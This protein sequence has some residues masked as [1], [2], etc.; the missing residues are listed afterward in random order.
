MN[1]LSDCAPCLFIRIIVC[2]SVG[3]IPDALEEDDV[4]QTEAVIA[5]FVGGVETT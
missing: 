2:N 4:G 3:S 1:L 5:A